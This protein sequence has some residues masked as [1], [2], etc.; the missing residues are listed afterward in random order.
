MSEVTES[1]EV[2]VARGAE[3][4]DAVYPEWWTRIDLGTLELS[5]SCRCVLGQIAYLPGDG[6]EDENGEVESGFDRFMSLRFAAG[7]G[8]AWPIEYG[9][10]TTATGPDYPALDEAWISEIKR[11]WEAGV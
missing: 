7:L 8:T 10:D 2:R 6:W 1:V 3:W 4:L 5:D 9:F 11:R